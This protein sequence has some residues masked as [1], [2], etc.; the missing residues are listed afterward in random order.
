MFVTNLVDQV[1]FLVPS[2]RNSDPQPSV[3][4]SQ[5]YCDICNQK[6]FASVGFGAGASPGFLDLHNGAVQE[7]REWPESPP[8]AL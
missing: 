4:A 2:Q 6:L 5:M 1:F 7:S 8:G 3:T